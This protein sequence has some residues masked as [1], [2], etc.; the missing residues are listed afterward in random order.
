MGWWILGAGAG[1]GVG[2]GAGLTSGF[3]G[4]CTSGAGFVVGAGVSGVVDSFVLLSCIY[5][6]VL[7]PWQIYLATREIMLP[8]EDALRPV[9]PVN[10]G[11]PHSSLYVIAERRTQLR[12]SHTDFNLVT[13]WLGATK[14]GF[15]VLCGDKWLTIDDVPAGNALLWR[16]HFASTDEEPLNPIQHYAKY[17]S[18]RRRIVMIA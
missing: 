6:N 7:F 16:G 11:I 10:G 18:I 9:K 3:G 13:M 14:P 4:A 1:A 12:P 2:A 5:E 8:L 15:K 17:R